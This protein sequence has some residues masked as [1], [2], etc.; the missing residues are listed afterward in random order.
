MVLRFPPSRPSKRKSFVLAATLLIAAQLAISSGISV[1]FDYEPG[2]SSKLDGG[3]NLTRSTRREEV[4]TYSRTQRVFAVCPAISCCLPVSFICWLGYPHS[5]KMS[6]G[7]K[8]EPDV[9]PYQ[10]DSNKDNSC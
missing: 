8:C 10:A 4:E 9:N 1:I 3:F 6:D 7:K 2:S 5:E